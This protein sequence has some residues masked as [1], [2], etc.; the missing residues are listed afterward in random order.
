MSKSSQSKTI[1]GI[2]FI[3]FSGTNQQKK[4]KIKS[5]SRQKK[6]NRKVLQFQYSLLCNI[7]FSS[8]QRSINII[9]FVTKLEPSPTNDTKIK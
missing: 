2:T 7:F 5:E 9:I 4:K 3:P 8:L 6:R 1:N